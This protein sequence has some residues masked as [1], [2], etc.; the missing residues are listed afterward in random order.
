[1]IRSGYIRTILLAISA[2]LL[3]AGCSTPELPADITLDELEAQMAQAMDPSGAYR[4]AHSYFQRQNIIEEGFWGPKHQLV[5]VKFQRPDKYKLLYYRENQV[6]SEILGIGSQAWL[7]DHNEGI[8]SEITGDNLEK[9]KIMF[10]LAHPDTDFDKLFDRVDLTL[11]TL[12]DD[13]EYYKLSCYP[14]LP[15]SNPIIIYVDKKDMLPRRMI[16]TIKTAD[17]EKTSTS[18]IEEYQRFNQIMLPALTKVTEDSREY[19]T[20]IV[21]YLLNAHFSADEFK[22]PQFDP[23]LMEMKR[24]K[25]RRR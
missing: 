11:T 7:I 1:M 20:R 2:V 4:R 23:I 12:D 24:Q 6:V 13:R 17:G 14:A 8:I 15:G 25:K 3:T 19:A 18:I 10:A 5:E 9:I 16:V 22:I 21:G